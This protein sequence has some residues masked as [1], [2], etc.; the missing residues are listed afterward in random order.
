MRKQESNIYYFLI[1]DFIVQINDA[2]KIW[3]N[4]FTFSGSLYLQEDQEINFSDFYKKKLSKNL[5]IKAL[6]KSGYAVKV[7]LPIHNTQKSV[8]HEQ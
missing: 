5:K 8:W 1:P 3:K 6:D 4:Y 2:N 7:H